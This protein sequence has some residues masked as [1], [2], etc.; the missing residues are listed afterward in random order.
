MS[1]LAA[2]TS[3]PGRHQPAP[4]STIQRQGTRTANEH[5]LHQPPAPA[6]GFVVLPGGDHRAHLRDP[7]PFHHRPP[8]PH[9]RPAAL[10]G[11]YATSWPSDND[12]DRSTGC[13]RVPRP[14]P[15]EA[16]ASPWCA[17]GAGGADGVP[18]SATPEFWRRRHP[19]ENA[20]FRRR[21]MAVRSGNT[22]VGTSKCCDGSRN[23]RRTTARPSLVG[24]RSSGE[25]LLEPYMT[26][27]VVRP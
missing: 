8:A 20:R 12:R 14:L 22:C 11:N 9:P 15:V 19:S 10:Y 17:A 23:G 6:G 13:G 25:T 18:F 5:R 3:G 16:L 27:L 7:P 1:S 21:A 2:L 4:L 26:E 24:V